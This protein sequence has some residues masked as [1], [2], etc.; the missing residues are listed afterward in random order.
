VTLPRLILPVE[1]WPERD[2][3]EWR[4]V[5]RP[6]SFLEEAR[7][8]SHWSKASR[9]LAESGYGRWLAFLEQ[10][11]LLDPACAPSDRAGEE[12][13]RAY[14]AE[15]QAR[16]AP[17]TVTMAV[18][19]LLRMLS[20]LAPERDWAFLRRAHRHLKR[21]ALPARDK[22]AHMVPAADLFELGIRL[23]ETADEAGPHEVS[24]AIRYRD[25][26]L[27]A[28]LICCP[29]RLK[30]LSAIEVGRQL[31][32]DGQRYLL[33]FSAAETKTGQPHEAVI[34]P[35][36][37]RYIDR[38]LRVHRPALQS[39]ARGQGGDAGRHLWLG[40]Q[41]RPAAAS[42]IRHQIKGHTKRA[43]GRAI[44]PHLFRDCAVTE[45]VHLAPEEI[46]LAADLLGHSDLRT[47]RKHY[48]HAQGMTAHTRVQEVIQR[49]RALACEAEADAR[50]APGHLQSIATSERS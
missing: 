38:W 37:T 17:T 35:E 44:W 31:L 36:L 33:R 5:Q 4:L 34:A 10:K 41:G 29:V 6:A 9:I 18:K 23:M 25:G 49:R 8:A 12:R 14:V 16:L 46:A 20:I 19:A 39:I 21:T 30:N 11:G 42:A 40:R 15:L 13:L 22:L 48:I 45:L 28:L 1:H 24:R 7:P 2:R 47:T 26:L 27:I 43:F 32:F 50:G 3:E